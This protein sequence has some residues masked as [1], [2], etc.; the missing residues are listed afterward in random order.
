MATSMMIPVILVWFLIPHY[1][2]AGWTNTETSTIYGVFKYRTFGTL[3]HGVALLFYF[4]SK[5]S[6]AVNVVNL[7]DTVITNSSNNTVRA[8]LAYRF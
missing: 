3:A 4:A 2:H 1:H 6:E 5:I 8:H 7:A